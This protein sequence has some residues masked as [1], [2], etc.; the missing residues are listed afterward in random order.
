MNLVQMPNW[1]LVIRKSRD[2]TESHLLWGQLIQLTHI[3][4]AAD[5]GQFPAPAVSCGR[6]QWQCLGW[7]EAAMGLHQT[8]SSTQLGCFPWPRSPRGWPSDLSENSMNQSLL[9]RSA[10]YSH[11]GPRLSLLTLGLV[12]WSA[13]HLLILQIFHQEASHF[14]FA[15]DPTNYIAEPAVSWLISLGLL[16]PWS[17]LEVWWS[18]WGI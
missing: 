6:G 7:E 8:S 4:V 2:H 16:V 1:K 12:K 18:L 15:L 5:P 11:K 10:I 14:H 13:S 9:H 17:P 3:A